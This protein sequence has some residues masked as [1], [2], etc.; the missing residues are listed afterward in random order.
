M[1]FSE[2]VALESPWDRLRAKGEGFA[3]RFGQRRTISAGVA[4]P[5]NRSAYERLLPAA[6]ELGE[7]A[8]ASD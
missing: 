3:S 7:A 6:V 4:I 8:Q 1:D 2:K 5:E